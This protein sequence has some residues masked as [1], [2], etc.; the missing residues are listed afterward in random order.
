V[1]ISGIIRISKNSL[2]YQIDTN[3]QMSLIH[4]KNFITKYFTE[5]NYK[6]AFVRKFDEISKLTPATILRILLEETQKNPEFVSMIVFD[7]NNKV[8]ERISTTDFELDIEKILK[9]EIYEKLSKT[10]SPQLS[11]IK[12]I[13]E[14][15]VI[16]ILYPILNFNCVHILVDLSKLSKDILEEENLSQ[17]R[18]FLVNKNGEIILC[19]ASKFVGKKYNNFDNMVKNTEVGL[20]R[21]TFNFDNQE[22]IFKLEKLQLNDQYY[23][24]VEKDVSI[25]N[26]PINFMIMLVLGWTLVVLGVSFIFSLI[27]SGYIIKPVAK[28]VNGMKNL[29]QGK[30]TTIEVDSNDEIGFL[31][32][33]FNQTVEQIKDLQKKLVDNERLATIGQM[34]SMVGHE[35]RNPLSAIYMASSL[36][37][38][39]DQKL[40]VKK[41]AL[42]IKQEAVVINKIAENLLG[43]ARSRPPQKE[44]INLNTLFEEVSANLKIPP[45]VKLEKNIDP[46]LVMLG[47]QIEIRQVLINLIDNALQAMG[48]KDGG[49]VI[50]D[51]VKVPNNKIK[52]SVTD[53]GPGI[54]E[55]ILKKIF[56]PL[57][58][59]K[60]KGTG[61]GLAVVK[62][63]VE[64]HNGT[65][66]VQSKVGVGTSFI[67]TFPMN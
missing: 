28:L 47:E 4:T 38:S 58:S 8:V 60:P 46:E 22:V 2:L 64:R 59:T 48:N 55:D 26:K 51:I 16:E 52:I 65:I 56:E 40:D 24:L 31:A 67:L 43:Y 62:R 41:F 3:Q 1:I 9:S 19:G 34:S 14:T 17:S 39:G 6:M 29:A 30:F 50:V 49:K 11:E 5:L 35:I 15:P 13:N 36:L 25:I 63:V 21:K 45:K 37:A 54:P 7:K 20:A 42:M 12:Y 44:K 57:F 33:S 66:E 23:L 10:R 53:N 27:I 18:I 61:L 32:K